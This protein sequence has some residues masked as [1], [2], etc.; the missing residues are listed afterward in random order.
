MSEQ[1][2]QREVVKL[3]AHNAKLVAILRLLVVLLKVCNVTLLQ[4]RVADGEKKRR[5]LQA[6]ER[7]R[8]VLQLRVVLRVLGLSS[9][10]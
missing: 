2:L 3:R 6:V 1:E 5:I 10:R 8:S 7:S 4:R 9:T